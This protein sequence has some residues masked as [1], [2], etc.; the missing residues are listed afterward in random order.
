MSRYNE[1]AT[2]LNSEPP[3]LEP[4]FLEGPDGGVI[5]MDW[6]EGFMD[7]FG[8]RDDQWVELMETEEGRDWMLPILS[9]LFDDEGNSLVGVKEA[10][11]PTLLDEA[12][13]LIAEAVP[14]VFAYWQ[15]KRAPSN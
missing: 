6:C 15:S 3:Y 9:H 10:D 1:I 5:A 8:L 11:M 7:A 13:E 12:Q 14:K 4:L 2:G